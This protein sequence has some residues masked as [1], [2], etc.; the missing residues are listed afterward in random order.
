MHLVL[1]ASRKTIHKPASLSTKEE[2]SMYLP[3]GSGNIWID[4]RLTAVSIS[5][6]G[7]A[8]SARPT[9]HV[10]L[11]LARLVSVVHRPWHVA[12]STRPRRDHDE[13]QAS[14][15]HEADNEESDEQQTRPV[16][17]V[18][19]V[20]REVPLM[21]SVPMPRLYSVSMLCRSILESGSLSDRVLRRLSVDS[22][23]HVCDGIQRSAVLLPW[24]LYTVL[25][26]A[27]ITSSR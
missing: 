7:L 23:S 2:R 16:T 12:A 13:S 14:E 22:L 20:L 1:S 5:W 21:R 4:I 3:N 15:Q 11:L 24:D 25:D 8:V 26:V 27:R 18:A 17:S 10:W 6:H 19:T 9:A